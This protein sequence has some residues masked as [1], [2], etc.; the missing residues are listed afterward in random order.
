MTGADLEKERDKSN[1][2]R[3]VNDIIPKDFRSVFGHKV[4]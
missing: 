4:G 3:E 1:V 2:E